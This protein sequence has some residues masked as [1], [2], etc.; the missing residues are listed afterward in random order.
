MTITIADQYY[1]KAL[2]EYPYALDISIE[3]LNYALSYN[4]EHVGANFLM[5]RVYMEQFDNYDKAEEYFQEALSN[6][7][8]NY[9]VCDKYS[10]MLI[11]IR[12]YDKAEK[13]IKH[14]ESLRGKDLGEL[15]RTKAYL[16]EYRKDYEKAE[17]FLNMAM[18]ET[19][20]NDFMGFLRSELDRVQSKLNRTQ[21]YNYSVE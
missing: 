20:N 5:G 9:K 4:A 16:S 12:E 21:R 18:E 11:E 7:P 15:F 8:S 19:Y 3:Y 1:L 17:L 14:M 6:D 2:D 13:L 10:L